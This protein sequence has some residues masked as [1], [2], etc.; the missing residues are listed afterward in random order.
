VADPR[1]RL[2]GYVTGEGSF[3]QVTRGM[4]RALDAAGEKAALCPLDFED[5]YAVLG[6]FDAPISL[7]IG[8]PSG[9]MQAHRRGS[10]K[11]HWLLLAPNGE[12]LPTGF[13]ETLLLP[14][15]VL[16]NGLLTG[17]LLAPSAWAASVLRRVVPELVPIVIA[18]HGVTREV[19]YLAPELRDVV[20]K[21]YREEKFRVLHMTS[22]ETERKGTKL[23]LRAWKEAKCGGQLPEQAKLYVVMNPLHTSKV[24]WWCADFGLTAADIE[25]RP[26]LAE[27]H[28]GIA[29]LYSAMHAVCQ[30]SRGEGF[31]LV[32]LEALAC[33]VPVIATAC[34]GHAEYLGSR[35]PGALIVEH[36]PSGS[37]DDFPGS[38]APTVTA[39][40]IQYAL[41]V[42]YSHWEGLASG[43]EQNA[44]ALR[45]EW[46]WENKNGPA[47]RRMIQEVEKHGN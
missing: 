17:G 29:A 39:E 13:I 3:T 38:R 44:D 1:V 6:G 33:G 8:A 43:A 18:P 27:S 21:G 28:E 11:S 30:P 36:G 35:P 14:S 45:A 24:K 37:M 20:R 31:G 22:S 16:P 47:I 32:P 26:G 46:S 25:I 2:Y 40:A 15:G 12:T 41:G 9:L 19:H 4:H 23:L 10:H 34:T 5:E 42:A 7:N